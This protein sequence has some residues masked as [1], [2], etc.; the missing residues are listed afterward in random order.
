[1]TPNF[2][3]TLT[4]F[5]V[6]LIFVSCK[7]GIISDNKP[8]LDSIIALDSTFF[9]E[10]LDA[11]IVDSISEVED[12]FIRHGLVDVQSIDPSILVDLKYASTDN[13]LDTNLYGTITKAY[14]QKEV[15]EKLANASAFLK[16]ECDSC[17]L[18]VFDAARPQSV[19]FKMWKKIKSMPVQQGIYVSNPEKGSVHN[20]GAA[21]DLTII[22]ENGEE[23]DMGTPFDYFGKEAWTTNED[24]LIRI[25]KLSPTQVKNRLLLRR[26]M[27]KAGFNAI[28]SEWWHFN[29]YSRSKAQEIYTIIK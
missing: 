21:V 3:K 4:L 22:T 12:A 10:M 5:C 11:N 17:R 19:Q 6:F 15:A 25:G 13:F 7:K 2:R 16:E 26:A 28:P 29:A 20:F 14:L 27:R 23:L 8:N 9:I 24:S 1:M 18:L